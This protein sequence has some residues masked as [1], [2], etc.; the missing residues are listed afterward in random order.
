VTYGSFKI[1][2]ST[3]P[4]DL[5]PGESPSQTAKRLARLKAEQVAIRCTP[6]YTILAADTIVVI[7]QDILGKPVNDPEALS[8]LKHLSG[9]THQVITGYILLQNGAKVIVH[10]ACIPQ[11]T[12]RDISDDEIKAYIQTGEPMDKAGAY[13]VQGIGKNFITH[14]EGSI[15]NVIGLPTEDL[16]PYL[17]KLS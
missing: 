6:P 3:A 8:H 9:R 15:N 12:M 7:D 13:A 11:V 4:E 16:E 2:P 14:V 5:L 17:K 1:I 10:D